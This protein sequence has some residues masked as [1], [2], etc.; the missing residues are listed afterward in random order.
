MVKLSEEGRLKA[1]WEKGLLHQ[2]DELQ[3][4]SFGEI[5]GATPVNTWII[6]KWNSLMADMEEVLVVWIDK[7]ATTTFDNQSLIQSK[8]LTL[9]NSLRTE[10][11]EEAAEEKWSAIK[12]GMPM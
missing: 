12:W 9:F 6:R 7:Q 10:R 4:K 1:D 11:G 3:R 2:L 8:A 5:T